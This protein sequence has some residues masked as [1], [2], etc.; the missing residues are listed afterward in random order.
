MSIYV[1][2]LDT[3]RKPLLPC[4]P[5]VARSLLNHGK[6]AVFRRFPFTIII[7]KP[8]GQ[9]VGSMTA[10]IDPGSKTTGIAVLDGDKVV[11]GMELTHRGQ[12]IK[13]KLESRR[14]SR[15]GRRNRHTRYRQAR[16]LNRTKPKGWLAPSLQ[17]RVLTTM[18]WV[19]RLMKLMPITAIVQELVRFDMQAMQDPDI[20][21]VAYQQGTLAGYEIRQYLLEK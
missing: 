5:G 16:F 2:V 1:C 3:N 8:V 4:K 7:N 10:K 21:G 18:T 11:F 12:M 9:V 6:A 17:H 13:K 19:R 15:R 20:E 14:A